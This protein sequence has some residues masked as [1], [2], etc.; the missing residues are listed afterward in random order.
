MRKCRPKRGKGAGSHARCGK[1]VRMVC[2][3]RGKAD[4]CRAERRSAGNSET[5]G[6]RE[7]SEKH[8]ESA[9]SSG[10]ETHGI[11]ALLFPV[12]GMQWGLCVFHFHFCLRHC[13]ASRILF[14]RIFCN[15]K[16]VRFGRDPCEEVNSLIDDRRSHESHT[17]GGIRQPHQSPEYKLVRVQRP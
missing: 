11:S 10:R 12:L 5:A 8:T 9:I 4:K 6:K 17:S 7:R 13:L 1:A 2:D 14:F 15:G 3:K 16:T